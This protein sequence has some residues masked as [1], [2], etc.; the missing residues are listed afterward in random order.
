MTKWI[1]MSAVVA[2]GSMFVGSTEAQEQIRPA[3]T[4]ITSG[5]PTTQP[6]TGILGR[7]RGRRPMTTTAEPM[8]ATRYDQPNAGRDRATEHDDDHADCRP[9]AM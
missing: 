5:Q 4:V 2:V 7:M 8:I 9:A 6:R 3:G 1:L